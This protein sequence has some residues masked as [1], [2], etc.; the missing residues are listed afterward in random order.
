[1]VAEALVDISL[2]RSNVFLDTSSPE[3]D[4]DVMAGDSRIGRIH[5]A[6]YSAMPWRWSLSQFIAP[7]QSG[8]SATRVEAVAALTEAYNDALSGKNMVSA[9]PRNLRATLLMQGEDQ[10]D[11]PEQHRHS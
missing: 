1:M 6:N 3:D 7:G 8:K 4:F 10:F 5:S 2:R 9:Q 11:R